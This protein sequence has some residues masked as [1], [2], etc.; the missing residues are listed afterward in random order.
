MGAAFV[1]PHPTV[2]PKCRR[3]R[4]QG[5]ALLNGLAGSCPPP[6]PPPPVQGPSW[7]HTY[8]RGGVGVVRV[9]FLHIGQ[10]SVGGTCLAT[11]YKLLLVFYLF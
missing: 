3:D 1:S 4:G 6:P 10:L 7:S 9:T 8:G 11:Y 2:C 5:Q